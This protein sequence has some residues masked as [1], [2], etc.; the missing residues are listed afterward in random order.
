[1]SDVILFCDDWPE[2]AVI[3]K[4][5]SP[6]VKLKRSTYRPFR[7]SWSPRQTLALQEHGVIL[8]LPYHKQIKM[9]ACPRIARF[10][11]NPVTCTS[12]KSF[13]VS[14]KPA[15]SQSQSLTTDG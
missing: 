2:G 10:R 5:E 4:A 8:E 15:Q 7:P 9:L 6:E 1:M 14:T 12:G 11:T 3:T 13:R